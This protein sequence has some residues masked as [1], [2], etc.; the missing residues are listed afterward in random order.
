MFYWEICCHVVVT[1]M[2]LLPIVP[3]HVPGMD[4]TASKLYLLKLYMDMV[5]KKGKKKRNDDRLPDSKCECIAT[6][7]QK[8]QHY[9]S[10]SNSSDIVDQH[11]QI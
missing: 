10:N 11:S 1:D 6:R 5:A 8:Q 4:D 7:C 3:D 2:Y 9:N